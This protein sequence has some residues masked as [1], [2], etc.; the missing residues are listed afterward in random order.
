M[1][2]IDLERQLVDE[3]GSFAHDRAIRVPMGVRQERS[4]R[5]RRVRGTGSE[6]FWRSLAADCAKAVISAGYCRR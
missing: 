4:L 1:K 6:S 5:T 3:I 2:S